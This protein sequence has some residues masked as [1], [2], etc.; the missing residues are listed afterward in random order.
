[1]PYYQHD[2]MHCNQSRCEKKDQ[3]Y[4]YWLAQEIKNTEYQYASAYAPDPEEELGDKCEL[5][6]DLEIAK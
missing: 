1:M 6:L 3:C 5:F 4:R 2:M